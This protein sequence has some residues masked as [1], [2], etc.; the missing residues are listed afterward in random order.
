MDTHVMFMSMFMFVFT[1]LEMCGVVRGGEAEGGC[2]RA[3]ISGYCLR[4]LA[5]VF[6]L[7]PRI[8]MGALGCLAWTEKYTPNS[9]PPKL[10]CRF[11]IIA[12]VNGQ[13]FGM[14]RKKSG[15]TLIMTRIPSLPAC[16]LLLAH[17][18]MGV[19]YLLRV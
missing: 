9:Y 10:S 7:V 19:Y 6:Y 2:K 15:A 4:I 14:T 8:C 5:N 11:S 17:F 13:T 12:Y 16:S 3:N 1:L 18:S